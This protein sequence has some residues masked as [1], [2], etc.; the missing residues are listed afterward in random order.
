M[1]NLPQVGRLEQIPIVLPTPA[2]WMDHQ[3]LG[4]PVLPAVEAMEVLARTIQKIFGYHPVRR[5]SQA[6]FEKFLFLNAEAEQ[7]KAIIELQELENGSIQA[8]LL[9]RAKAPKAAITRAKVHARMTLAPSNGAF[10]PP[11]LE[12]A[13]F[14]EGVCTTITPESIYVDLVPFGPAFRNIKAPLILSAEGALA[15]IETPQ[16][17]PADT[18]LQPLLGS[19]FALDAAFHAACVWAQH[20]HGIVAFPVA[21]DHRSI[22]SPTRAGETYF[23]RIFP[24]KSDADRLSFDIGLMDESGRVCE[25]VEGVQMRDVSAGRLQPPAWIACTQRDDPLQELRKA[26]LAMSV[27]ELDGVTSLAGEMLTALERQKYQKMV[28]RRRKSFMAARLALKHLFRQITGQHP[29]VPA[30]QI[31]TVHEDSALP[32]MGGIDSKRAY[33]CSVSHDKR[34]AIAVA[35]A[36]I[37]GVDVEVIDGKIL[38]S[39]NIFMLKSEREM[40][41]KSTLDQRQAAVR[42]WSI[43]EAVAK[44]TGM[45]LAEAWERVQ[46]TSLHAAQSEFSLAHDEMTALHAVVDDHLFTLV[47][48]RNWSK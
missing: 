18:D 3:F 4:Q 19:P 20:Y 35:D 16:T 10:N 14:L 33:H 40:I 22:L 23:G 42:I 30:N 48:S 31:E 24:K 17:L 34:F 2:Y 12:A 44:A 9:T 8:S 7:L 32:R 43:K 46:V 11:S 25:W 45:R 27:V 6:R 37:L 21:V 29:F 13:V 1:G 28:G 38:N 36:R 39:K 47:P 5:I 41:R 15:R 26:C